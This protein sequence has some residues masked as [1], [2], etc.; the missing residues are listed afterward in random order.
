MLAPA[1]A[2]CLCRTPLLTLL[3]PSSAVACGRSGEF[4]HRHSRQETITQR[5]AFHKRRIVV[6][7][8][9]PRNARPYPAGARSPFRRAPPFFTPHGFPGTPGTSNN[10]TCCESR[11][12]VVHA[13]PLTSCDGPTPFASTRLR[14]WASHRT[15]FPFQYLCRVFVPRTE[16]HKAHRTSSP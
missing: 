13:L 10:P 8:S 16:H 12:S 3:P 11:P 2:C 1:S 9:R 4:R 5:S 15:R 6:S 14:E 7:L